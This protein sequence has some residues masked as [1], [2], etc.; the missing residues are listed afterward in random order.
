MSHFSNPATQATILIVDDHVDNLKL[1]SDMLDEQGYETRQSLNG[2]TALKSIEL[3]PP[4]LI[5]LDIKM[6]D[7]DGYTVCERLKSTSLTKDIPVIFISASHEEL[8][9][10]KAF[11]VG[12]LDYITKPFQWFEVLARIENQLRIKQLQQE[13]KEKN[14]RLEHLVKEL[15]EKSRLDPLTQIGNRLHFNDCFEQ[16]W[17]RGMRE[18]EP[19]GLILCDIDHF[20]LY[21]DAY[22]HLK[23]DRC[24]CAVAKGLEK[25]V[26]RGTDLV[27]RYGGEEFAVILPNTD[28]SGAEPIC[29]RIVETINQ[30]K[31]PHSASSVSSHVT[32]SLGFASL[33]PS[34]NLPS[35]S[36]ISMSDKALYQAKSTGK[37]CFFLYNSEFV[38]A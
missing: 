28:Y 22:G 36:L 16:E 17:K 24:L 3:S 8:D 13:L 34:V 10:V 27:C 19:L 9:K 35:D 2:L 18:Q 14:T 25:A 23:G 31:I 26:L 38:L 33:I 7:I 37:N 11:S 29:Q 6:P 32:I 30:L 21:N 12:G 4:D 5:L 1:L 15:E 20:K